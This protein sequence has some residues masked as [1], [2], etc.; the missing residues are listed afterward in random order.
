M[1]SVR[2]KQYGVDEQGRP[3]PLASLVDYIQEQ[4]KLAQVCV[5]VRACVR[6]CVCMNVYI[7]CTCAYFVVLKAS[8]S[9]V[10]NNL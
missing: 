8:R 1:F 6:L 2:P 4:N 7:V 9:F 10:F 5:C 3:Q